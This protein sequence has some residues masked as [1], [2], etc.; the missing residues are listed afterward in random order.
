MIRAVVDDL[1]FVQADAVIR[2]TTSTM[3]PLSRSLRHLEKL[4]GETFRNQIP[5]NSELAVGSAVVSD[6]GDLEAGMVIHAVI[7]SVSD[8]ISEKVIKAALISALQRASDWQLAK[9][10]SPPIGT[11]AGNLS[12]EESAKV[13]VQVLGRAMASATYPEEVCIVLDSEE[14]LA[15]FQAYIKRIPQ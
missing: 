8:P 3:A 6:A 1:A 5:A 2:P 14:D 9:L 4:G 7:Q 13:M 12:I 10:V 15:V 11:G